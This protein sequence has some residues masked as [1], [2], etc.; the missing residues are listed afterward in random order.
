MTSRNFP[1]IS[2]CLP[3]KDEILIL[4]L[5]AFETIYLQAYNLVQQEALHNPSIFSLIF[6]LGLMKLFQALQLF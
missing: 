6:H 2:A 3:L 1:F 4:D 5:F